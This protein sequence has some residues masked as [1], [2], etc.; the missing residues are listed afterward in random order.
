M[1]AAE[2]LLIRR[3]RELRIDE[4]DGVPQ[5]EYVAS[6]MRNLEAV[7]FTFS[8]ALV[9]RLQRWTP[10]ELLDL[11]EELFP[12][13][14]R[15]VGGHVRHEPMYPDFPR[16]VME[17]EE[18]ELYLNACRHYYGDAV[19]ERILPQYRKSVRAPLAIPD[20]LKQLELAP[21]GALVELAR[22]LMGS[23][24][25]LSAN[26]LAD[27]KVLLGAHRDDL[28]G[29]LPEEI[30]FRE[31]RAKVCASLM[32]LADDPVAHIERY[33]DTATDVLRLATECS[34][35]DVSLATR[36]TYR[37]FRRRER[38][39]LLGLLERCPNLLEDMSRH[40]GKWLRVAER[41]HPGDFAKRFPVAFA[42]FSALRGGERV[43]SFHARVEGALEQGMLPEAVAL[44]AQRPGEFARRLD[45][46][47]RSA[48]EPS[49][50]L[51]SFEAVAS[52]V[53]TPVLLQLLAHFRE[54]GR[55]QEPRR[56]ADVPVAKKKGFFDR[57]LRALR[58]PVRPENPLTPMRTVFPKGNVGRLI[59]IPRVPALL[60]PELTEQVVASCKA[61]LLQRF[62]ELPPIG[63]AYLD[64][65]LER[66]VV[67]FSQ[68]SA[69]K[70]LRTLS[71]GTRLSLPEASTVRFFLWWRE[72]L[73]EGR[74]TG[75]VDI[76]LSAT[77]Y[78][79]GWGHKGH[80]SYTNL[81]DRRLG[82]V[83]SGDITSAPSGACE[84][85]DVDLPRARAA[86]ARFLVVSIQAFTSQ[87]F[88][89]LPECFA[90]FMAREKPQAGEVFEP[91]TVKDKVDLA[92]SGRISVPMVIDLE[93]REAYWA[94]LAL[95]AQ[96]N[97]LVNIESNRRGLVHYGV[98][99]T[100]LVRPTLHD[101]FEL[102]VRARG[103]AVGTAEEADTVFS[104]TRGVTPFDF[105]RIASEYLG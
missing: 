4:R 105:E 35:G 15:E 33:V 71:R 44:L 26:D 78:G 68:R 89:D 27:L 70:S 60:D 72:G 75:R 49:D 90:G 67:P 32:E 37:S 54:R 69:S 103:E 93:T 31:V 3:R 98:A 17:T 81:K 45:H 22:G 7:G 14:L 95:R 8:A 101:L 55:D 73:V 58:G 63:K 62:A 79:S 10:E 30:P 66:Y 12:L 94:D 104:E 38:R 86:G 34:G 39:N 96:P 51:R 24:T 29:L 100:T 40:R 1:N 50:V 21:E 57:A 41:L 42:A 88:C 92:S 53:S 28:A 83:H 36:T 82:T 16:Q 46:L 74:A 18:A 56:L 77:F 91:A 48:E 97:R 23:H 64:P 76:D 20:D 13:L 9:E 2:K 11:A 102:H 5:P 52:R 84:F 80:V 59:R 87:P 99:I 25:S 85:I 61:A 6:L 65:E 19:G 43:P 47:L